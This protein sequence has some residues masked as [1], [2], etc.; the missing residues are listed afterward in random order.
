VTPYNHLLQA[1]AVREFWN[2]LTSAGAMAL[3]NEITRQAAMIGYIND[4]KLMMLLTLA[5]LPLI[6]LLSSPRAAARSSEA[7]A[8]D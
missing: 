7:V 3:N 5:S 1:P 4:F 2:P 8:L 6:F